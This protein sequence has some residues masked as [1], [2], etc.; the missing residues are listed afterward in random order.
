MAKLDTLRE[1]LQC[2]ADVRVTADVKLAPYTSYGIGGPTAL[3]VVPEHPS[4]V[5]QVLKRVRQAQAPLFI[6]GSG[7]NVLISD[8]GWPGVTLWLGAEFSGWQVTPPRV[9]V[10]AGTP[11]NDL[12]RVLVS[13]GLGGLEMLAGI[14]GTVGG[15]L[16][17][18]AGAFGREIC[19]VTTAIHGFDLAG[20]PVFMPRRAVDFG[21]RRAPE[22]A[23]LVITAAELEFE[24][25][26][27]AELQGRLQ[28][29]LALRG[30]KQPLDHPSCGSV[31]KRPPGYYAGAL[32]EEA[33][34]K[35]ARVGDAMVS[36]RHAGFILNMGRATAG[37]I[38]ALI[39][40]IE[41]A[42]GERFGVQ[43]EREVR[44]VGDFSRVA[45]SP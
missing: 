36:P 31:F 10:L 11:L 4:A 30:K 40:K 19:E 39:R 28:E 5:G 18:N 2:L 3:W 9:Q 22:L 38:Y 16:R 44:L 37:D 27:A 15:A 35:G 45:A 32:I 29:I 14:P 23:E 42:V 17:M 25:A 13:K 1:E 12:I 34:L 8:E 7:S 26:D 24:A 43:L 21:Y 20:K 6:L 41:A 33:G